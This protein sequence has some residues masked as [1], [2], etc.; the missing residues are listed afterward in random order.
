MSKL[1]GFLMPDLQSASSL[2][3]ASCF[4]AGA[5]HDNALQPLAIL[6]NDVGD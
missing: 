1:P 3:I 2:A 5:I 6:S 4:F